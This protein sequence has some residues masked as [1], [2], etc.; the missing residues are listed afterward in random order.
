MPAAIALPTAAEMP[1]Q[2]PRTCRR[3]PRLCTGALCVL[4]DASAVVDNRVPG[5]PQEPPSYWRLQKLQ[6]EM[7]G[8]ARN[9]R[10]RPLARR[11]RGERAVA[12]GSLGRDSVP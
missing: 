3:R 6:A 4:E 2:T 7:R 10:A 9:C 5:E 12:A 8:A 1:N 11:A